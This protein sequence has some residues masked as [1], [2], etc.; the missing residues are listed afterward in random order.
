VLKQCIKVTNTASRILGIRSFV[1]EST[2]NLA[3]IQVPSLITSRVLSTGMETS[4]TERYKVIRKGPALY[5]QNAT[6]L[7]AHTT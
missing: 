2:N 5:N 7:R 4:F 6:R 3:V 1:Y